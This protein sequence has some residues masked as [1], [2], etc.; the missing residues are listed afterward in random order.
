MNPIIAEMHN[1]NKFNEY[2]KNIKENKAPIS[3]LGLAGVGLEQI[4][5]ATNTFTKSPICLITYNELQARRVADN[6]KNYID[7]VYFF[8]KREILS[9]DY[10]AE[11]KELPYER[12]EVLKKIVEKKIN[13]LVVSIE[14]LMQPMISKNV[15]FKNKI[16]LEV[17]KSYDLDKLKAT[18]SSLGYTR[19]ELIEAKGE[20]SIRGGILDIS[21][22]EKYGIRIEFW[23]DEIDSIRKFSIETQRSIEMIDKVEINPIHEYLLANDLETVCKKILDKKYTDKQLENVK[24]DIELIKSKE[25]K[26]MYPQSSDRPTN[27][28]LS[29]EKLHKIGINPKPWEEAL[30]EYLKEELK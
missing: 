1:S 12:I 13:V 15:L 21:F 4:V 11:S 9:Y 7:N 19:N 17:G 14:S 3:V 22:D 24:E 23:G 27:S 28:K 6:L 8:P 30:K 10:I 18:I 16:K 2:I 26:E 5:G 29:K 25:Y 20:F